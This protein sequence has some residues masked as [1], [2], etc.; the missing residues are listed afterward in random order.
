MRGRQEQRHRPS[1]KE[2]LTARTASRPPD[3]SLLQQPMPTKHQ[4]R[5]LCSSVRVLY[6]RDQDGVPRVLD[7]MVMLP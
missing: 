2:G 1:S 4:R 6:A 7:R 5:L 3:A